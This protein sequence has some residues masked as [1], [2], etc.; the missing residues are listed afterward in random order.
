MLARLLAPADFGL[1]G[2]TLLAVSFLDTFSQSGFQS[3]LIH[4]KGDIKPYLDTSFVVQ[5]VRG[6]FI[7]LL[8]CV[9]APHIA[10]F[11]QAPAATAML[12]VVALAMFI[13]GL[14]NIATIYLQKELEFKKYFFY[15]VVG[16]LA[17]FSFSVVL[18]VMFRSVWA[19][20]IGYL[21][22]ITARTIVSYAIYFYLPKLRFDIAKAKEL[23]TYGKW[24][25]GTN[26]IGFFMAQ[27]DSF[28]VA[29]VMG[30]ASLGFYQV[31]YK[32]P[33]VLNLEVL[34]GATFPAYSKL[35]EDK[36][37]LREAYLK[38]TKMF[39]LAVM[40]MAAGIYLLTPQF[41]MLFLGTKWLPSLWPMRILALSALVWTMA[42]VSD[43]LFLAVGKPHIHARWTSV[44]FFMM[45]A[46][47]Y[48]FIGAH[49]L[50]GAALVV[51]AGSTVATFGLTLEAIKIIGCGLSRFIGNVIFLFI[52]A[53]IM[54]G[55]VYGLGMIL[56][57]T[58]WSFVFSIVAGML[59]YGALLMVSDKLFGDRALRL[60]KES[61]GLLR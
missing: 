8:L 26:I 33:S 18:A 51:L 13:Q 48:P 55:V 7:A 23:F 54:A 31:A 3:A 19:L 17:D 10:T 29:K 46:L 60:L 34:A 30:V 37:K 53:L 59:T 44:R 12:R 40:P 58:L 56:P 14:T 43:Y 47:L 22:G 38:I 25:F 5:A 45:V 52:D 35:Q 50:T 1:F 6:F 49:G 2:V 11:F 32:I 16:T 24:V 61:L 39:A 15:Q 20:V 57:V 41:I 4:K 28:F 42:V 27:V 21:A 9:F 36:E